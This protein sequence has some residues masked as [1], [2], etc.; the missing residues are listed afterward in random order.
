MRKTNRYITSFFVVTVCACFLV[1]C[2]RTFLVKPTGGFDSS[3]RFNF[4]ENETASEPSEFKIVEFVIQKKV[5]N[6]SWGTSWELSGKQSLSSIE[7]G[8]KYEGLDVIVAPEPL[9]KNTDYRVLVAEV[10]ATSPKGFAG[11]EFYF[12]DSGELVVKTYD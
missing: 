11:S 3:V 6:D 7:Y 2:S 10:S 1:G 12:T 5:D 9:K 4:Y 8:A